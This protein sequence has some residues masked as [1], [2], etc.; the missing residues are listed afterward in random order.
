M[1]LESERLDR[2]EQHLKLLKKDTENQTKTLDSIESALVGNIF[3]GNKGLTHIVHEIDSRVKN[4]EDDY[5][6]TKE[7][8]RQLRIVCGLLLVSFFSYI[9]FIITK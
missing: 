2:M 6:V 3:N 4:L 8:M 1:S 5:S 7:N 9:L